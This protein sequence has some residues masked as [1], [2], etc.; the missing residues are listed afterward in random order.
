[1]DFSAVNVKAFLKEQGIKPNDFRVSSKHSTVKVPLCFE[2]DVI[3]PMLKAKF[4]SVSRCEATGE[5][6]GGGNQFCFVSHEDNTQEYRDNAA[7][8]YTKCQ[9]IASDL[10]KSH[11]FDW[12]IVG[13]MA[14][15]LFVDELMPLVSNV[16][17]SALSLYV[18]NFLVF[19]YDATYWGEFRLTNRKKNILSIKHHAHTWP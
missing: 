12:S 15:R 13:H 6:L 7:F 11:G 8:I 5:I 2:L 9:E 10:Y 19:E 17:R 1:M 18:R 3:E 16:S 14:F 4:E